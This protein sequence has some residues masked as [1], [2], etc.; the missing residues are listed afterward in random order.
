MCVFSL[1]GEKKTT[2][3]SRQMHVIEWRCD[4]TSAESAT[5]NTTIEM[6]RFRDNISELP[7]TASDR[8]KHLLIERYRSQYFHK[9]LDEW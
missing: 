1:N 8:R 6:L 2:H 9:R 3:L 4:N 5:D 7:R